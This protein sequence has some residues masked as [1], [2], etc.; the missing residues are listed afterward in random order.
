M[1]PSGI[2]PGA[3]HG[4]PL[5]MVALDAWP[6][7]PRVGDLI[8]AGFRMREPGGHEI[9]AARLRGRPIRLLEVAAPDGRQ[10]EVVVDARG[11]VADV[12]P[13]QPPSAPSSS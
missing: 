11:L 8:D 2:F 5:P 10:F 3:L 13:M 12:R 4:V 1:I 7:A 9:T 6:S